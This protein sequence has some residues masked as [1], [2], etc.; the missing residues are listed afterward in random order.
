MCEYCPR[1]DHYHQY[2]IFIYR[3]KEIFN[4]SCVQTGPPLSV[5]GVTVLLGWP[6]GSPA[7][8]SSRMYTSNTHSFPNKNTQGTGQ[9]LPQSA[10]SDTPESSRAQVPGA[11]WVPHPGMNCLWHSPLA[12]GCCPSESRTASFP[13][14]SDYSTTPTNPSHYS[15][16]VSGYNN[17][18]HTHTQYVPATFSAPLSQNTFQLL[19][20]CIMYSISASS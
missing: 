19:F 10:H 11:Q 18:A 20:I 1:K 14:L 13:R 7:D 3:T 8:I 16:N 9:Q 4:N 6:A 5:M 12:G 17:F 2:R 15:V